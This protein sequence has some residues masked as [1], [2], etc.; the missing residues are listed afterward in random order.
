MKCIRMLDLSNVITP[1]S[2]V[3]AYDVS[4]QDTTCSKYY[5]I[6]CSKG[7]VRLQLCGWMDTESLLVGGVCD[8][9]YKSKSSM[10]K[11]QSEFARLDT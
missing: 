10:F 1:M 3:P 5:N 8:S 2:N 11:E 9:D 6:N 4:L 7:G